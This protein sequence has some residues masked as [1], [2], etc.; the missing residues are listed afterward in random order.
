MTGLSGKVALVTGAAGGMGSAIARL[1]A[2][3]GAAVVIAD[4]RDEL[5][6]KFEAEIAQ[7]GG[8]ATYRNL[9]V[10][11][12]KAWTDTISGV[13]AWRGRLDILVN[14][15]GINIRGPIGGVNFDDWSKVLAVNLNGPLLGMKHAAPAIAR[16]GGGSIVNIT[17]NVSL[18]PSKSAAYTASK[19]GLRGLS[20]T[21]ALEYAP[22][23]I[24]VNSV[25]PGVVPTDIN[26]GQPYLQTTAAVTPLGRIASANDIANAVL[27]LVSDAGAFITGVDLPVDGGFTLGKSG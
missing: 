11:S 12:E 24:R 17:S 23:N 10:T 27:F 13:E 7:A 14:N 26:I 19:W 2:R 22:Q 4:L 16:A 21:A 25:G 15:A 3:E 20:K 8:I 9:D 6:R 1:L 18:I 5:G